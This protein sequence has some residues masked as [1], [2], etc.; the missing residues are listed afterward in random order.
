MR[1]IKIIQKEYTSAAT[2]QTSSAALKGSSGPVSS[3][4]ELPKSTFWPS[5][6]NRPPGP[7]A[8]GPLRCVE[9]N[10]MQDEKCSDIPGRPIPNISAGTLSN[11][12]T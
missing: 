7:L 6:Q 3:S 4:S 12:A 9:E 8:P 11:F 2:P 1:I 10:K 5:G